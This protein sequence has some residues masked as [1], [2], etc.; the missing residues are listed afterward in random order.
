M[1]EVVH[2]S[3]LKK[4]NITPSNPI[5]SAAEAAFATFAENF[6]AQELNSEDVS[7]LLITGD[8][9]NETMADDLNLGSWLKDYIN[10]LDQLKKGIP[11]ST[12]WIKAGA[13]AS[14]GFSLFK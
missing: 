2:S 12:N 13:K 11:K 7:V 14:G 5:V 1:N 6:A 8:Q 10:S 3:A 9:Q 4:M